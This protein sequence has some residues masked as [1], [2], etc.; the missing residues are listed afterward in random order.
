RRVREEG[1]EIGNHSY[2]HHVLLRYSMD[3]LERE[4]KEGE[5][6]IREVTGFSTKYFRP[7]KAW[8]TS[9]EKKKVESLGYKVVLWS[10]NSKDWV[11]F[12]DKYIVGYLVVCHRRRKPQRNSQEYPQVGKKIKRKG[13]PVCNHNRAFGLRKAMKQSDIKYILI[14]LGLSYL[15]FM[16]GSGG[17][18]LTNPDEVFYT[19]TARE[20][21]SHHSWLTPYLF[22]QPQF[23]KPILLY[24]FLRIAYLIFG[25]SSF[26]ARFFPA[27]FA[28]VGI[29]SVYFL[30]LL[31]F[32]DRKKAFLSGLLLASSGLYIGLARTV[33]T[34]LIFSVF[35]V[36]ALN[37][38]YLAYIDKKKEGIG[39]LL[40]FVFSGL[41]VLTKGPLGLL[42]PLL[43][44]FL[45][46]FFKREVKFLISPYFFWGALIFALLAAPWYVFMIRS[47]GHAFTHEFFYNDHIRRILEAEHLSNDTW[48]FYPLSMFGCM[49]PWSIFVAAAL[50]CL[51]RRAVRGF[52]SFQV[53]LLCWIGV[54]LVIFQSAHSKLVSYIFPLFPALAIVGG[55]FMHEFSSAQKKGRLFFIISFIS[56]AALIIFPVLL[57]VALLR[58]PEYLSDKRPVFIF[59]PVYLSYIGLNLFFVFRRKFLNC[60]YMLVFAIPL[61]LLF[62]AFI[63]K[64]V[65][66]YISSK[67]ACDFLLKNYKIDNA[68][69]CSKPYLRGVRYYS[70][71]EVAVADPYGS[72]FF[73]PHPVPFLDSDEKIRD[74]MKK[75]SVTYCVLKKSALS[76]IERAVAN[77]GRFQ[78]LKV[79]GNEYVARVD[80]SQPQ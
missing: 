10:L 74:F 52:S 17:L 25:I 77:Q 78:L 13:L 80:F 7:P 49:F 60:V 38:F 27:L 19:Q 53:F 24:I 39:I 69:V 72:N 76:D 65:E 43:I 5:R 54:G 33:F 6:V 44:I 75:Q 1:H 42:I 63:D 35:I 79:I 28:G 66:P 36:L 47:Y 70:D 59:I 57:A 37:L 20:M 2:D 40:F 34:D 45:F 16:L 55:D 62:F 73:S 58:F 3:S 51:V 23:E 68:I 50:V 9:E 71:K 48:Y 11:T 67:D 29:V 32:E 14:L 22:G 30:A 4:I 18:A 31:G 41:A 64:N 21:I 8:L 61:L 26:S 46:L 12:D 15:F 56:I